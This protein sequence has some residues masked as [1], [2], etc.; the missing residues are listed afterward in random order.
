MYK[1]HGYINS[2]KGDIV[3]PMAQSFGSLSLPI[4]KDFLKKYGDTQD[5][6]TNT[7]VSLFCEFDQLD[8]YQKPPFH[9]S[10][11]KATKSFEFLCLDL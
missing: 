8:R 3:Q 5:S 9:G 11:E 7:F 2:N 6:I 1:L 10:H 4:V